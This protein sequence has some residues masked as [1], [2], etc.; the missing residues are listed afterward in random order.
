MHQYRA[1]PIIKKKNIIVGLFILSF[2]LDSLLF[3]D[4]FL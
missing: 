3:F 4:D 2:Q 1:Y